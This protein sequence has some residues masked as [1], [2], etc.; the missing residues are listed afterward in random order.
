MADIKT[1]AAFDI[2]RA[3]IL[4]RTGRPHEAHSIYL[5]LLEPDANSALVALD[6]A[7]TMLDNG[8]IEQAESLLIAARD[9]ARRAGR[10]A[11]ERRAVQLLMKLA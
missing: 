3:E 4:A 2:W 10:H 8:H 7:L 6:G 1:A 11:I 9:S 5:G